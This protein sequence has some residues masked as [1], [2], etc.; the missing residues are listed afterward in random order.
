MAWQQSDEGD[1]LNAPRKCP[2][3]LILS[4]AFSKYSQRRRWSEVM[5]ALIETTTTRPKNTFR[6]FTT[7]TCILRP[8]LS[9]IVGNTAHDPGE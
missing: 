8:P 9:R 2:A 1:S 6:T 5:H 3:E 4:Q 7:E